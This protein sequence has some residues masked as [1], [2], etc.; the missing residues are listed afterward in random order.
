M[1]KPFIG[2][3]RRE[4]IAQIM[5]SLLLRGNA[6]L[7]IAQRDPILGWPL[8]CHIL[9]PDTVTPR[10]INGVMHYYVGS[11]AQT[12]I[13]SED[14]VHIRGMT[15]PGMHVGLSPIDLA[16][17]S[18]AVGLASRE[19]GSRFFAQGIN[20]AGVIESSDPISEDN[21]RRIA[22]RIQTSHGGSANAHLPLILDSGMSW[23]TITV[24]PEQ[25]Q[26]L[27]TQ[28]HSRSEV[29]TWFGVP[30]HLLQDVSK[31]T[32]WGTGIED[33]MIQ[34]VTFTVRAWA[35]RLEEAWDDDLL[36]RSNYARFDFES[37]LRANTLVRAQYYM[38]MRSIGAMNQ[39]EVRAMEDMPPVPDG[40]GQN[41][42]APMN[43]PTPQPKLT[44]P[45]G[46]GSTDDSKG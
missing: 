22:Q 16:A 25:S 41:F 35:Q 30:P 3:R 4:G 39:D 23:K 1:L 27:Q 24:T 21:A 12:E 13:P 14:L 44:E 33:Q 46:E 10:M 8:A 45:P 36:P 2:V 5:V 19:F 31:T 40:K 38:A 37:L 9:H 18:F 20:P 6:Y 17:Q 28:D 11:G 34:Y 7:V 15:L 29:A 32:S 42:A 43:A 26:F